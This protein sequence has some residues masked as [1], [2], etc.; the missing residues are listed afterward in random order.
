MKLEKMERKR[1]TDQ[2]AVGAAPLPADNGQ[3][4]MLASRQSAKDERNVTASDLVRW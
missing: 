4:L 2:Y 3:L 1:C